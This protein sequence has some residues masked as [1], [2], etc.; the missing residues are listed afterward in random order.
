MTLRMIKKI[1]HVGVV[2]AR[3]ARA[4]RFWRDAL[5]L[6]LVR[7]ADIAEQGVRAVLLAAG[8]S[9]IELLEPTRGD[10]GGARFLA[11]HGQGL[12]HACLET[13]NV[14]ADLGALKAQNVA[15]LDQ[16][17]RQGLAGRIAFLSPTACGGVLVEL[18]TP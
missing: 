7:E 2:V 16:V 9:E 6:P 17:P 11:K 14:D 13:P 4:S 10:T 15:L 3:L 12:H 8:D 18:A 1:H 5:G